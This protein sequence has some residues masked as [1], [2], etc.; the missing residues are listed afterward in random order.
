M[1]R[2]QWIL[3]LWKNTSTHDDCI[4]GIPWSLYSSNTVGN[5]SL[6]IQLSKSN[7]AIQ[8]GNCILALQ[9]GHCI[10]VIQLSNNIL[11]IQLGYFILVIQ[12][13]HCIL[14]IQ[15]GNSIL[16]LQLGHCILAIQ[17]GNCILAIQL[18]LQSSFPSLSCQSFLEGS[19]N[20]GYSLYV[21]IVSHNSDP[22]HLSSTGSQ[23]TRDFH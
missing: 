11:A 21:C 9:L 6:A 18:R 15:L 17:L 14:A 4:L 22:P 10:L 3:L 20:L 1:V 19:Q 2:E 5:C 7:L 12:L 16:P 13:G 8:L 23:A